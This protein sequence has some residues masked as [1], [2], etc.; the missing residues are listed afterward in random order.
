MRPSQRDAKKQKGEQ[1]KMQG[2]QAMK[3][4]E[5]QNGRVFL[6][7]SAQI[8]GSLDVQGCT[9]LLAVVLAAQLVAVKS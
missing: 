2:K 6:R 1:K 4:S 3:D 8:L 9:A 7:V 5:C